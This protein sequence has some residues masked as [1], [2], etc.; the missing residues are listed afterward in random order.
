MGRPL[1]RRTIVGILKN[2]ADYS[3][4]KREMPELRMLVTSNACTSSLLKFEIYN[5]MYY[6]FLFKR[7]I[8]LN[9]S[10]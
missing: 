5:F 9:R 4:R 8:V 1:T 2:Q 10:G 3:G 7:A 6:I